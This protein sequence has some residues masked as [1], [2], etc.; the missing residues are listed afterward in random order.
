MGLVFLKNIS[1]V[2]SKD[3]I[4]LIKNA[5]LDGDINPLELDIR[6]KSAEDVIT[7]IRKDPEIKERVDDEA[8]K[9]P[10]KTFSFMGAEITK[11][12]RK[13]YDFSND[14]VWKGL[15]AKDFAGMAR[16]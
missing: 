14:V 15:K 2:F 7:A 6:L 12:V 5:V 10:E 16:I 9:Y 4:E 11:N 3:F 1:R 13:N 8:S